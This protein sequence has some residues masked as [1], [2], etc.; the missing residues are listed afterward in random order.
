MKPT[1][2]SRVLLV[3]PDEGTSFALASALVR[4]GWTVELCNDIETALQHHGYDVLVASVELPERSGL[5]LLSELRSRGSEVPTLLTSEC[6]TVDRCRV[7]MRMGAHDLLA[8]PL[9]REDLMRALDALSPFG[10]GGPK[11]AVP[12]SSEATTHDTASSEDV[13]RTFVTGVG[14]ERRAI[15]EVLGQALRF[16]I[17]PSTRA[18][19]G[20]AC[21]EVLRNVEEHAYGGEA[22]LFHVETSVSRGEFEVR[23]R[24]DGQ[25]LGPI[26]AANGGLSRA[27][28]LA[29]DLWVDS[30]ATGT[31][32]GL[33]FA[34][35]GASFGGSSDSDW[36]EF[37]YLTPELLADVRSGAGQAA[38]GCQL[39]P[40]IAVV[41]GRLLSAPIESPVSG[42]KPQA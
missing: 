5:A 9:R 8:K 1:H 13:T 37:D 2:G 25:G 14:A 38:S 20:S 29:E 3:E 7:A 15:H 18:R 16:N 41:V 4:E 28:A 31:T 23:I 39:S 24:D 42:A 22:G 30:T 6:V 17:G 34:T 12:R 26:V 36:S 10:T 40:A 35:W 32:V 11:T 33:H 27:R 19:I 21:S